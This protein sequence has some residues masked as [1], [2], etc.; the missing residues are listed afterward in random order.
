M[1][2][3]RYVNN[4]FPNATGQP[5]QDEIWELIADDGSV[6]TTFK[7]QAEGD[8][9]ATTGYKV[10]RASLTQSGTSAPVATVFENTLGGT[11]VWTR[12][13]VGDYRATLAGA[14]PLT[15]TFI[16]HN[17]PNVFT[18]TLYQVGRL[19]DNE[20]QVTANVLNVNFGTEDA[21]WEGVDEA[22]QNVFHIGIIVYF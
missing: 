15:T 19:G 2:R 7:K 10:Y 22:L 20:L 12:N 16:T 1:W 21:A 5:V 8:Q 6:I 4:Y 18:G 3:K 13:A 14:F 11:V 17:C 9:T